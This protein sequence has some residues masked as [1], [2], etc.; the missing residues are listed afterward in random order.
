MKL[1]I[2]K[3]DELNTYYNN[4]SWYWSKLKAS[5]GK[6]TLKS[7]KSL[8]IEFNNNDQLLDLKIDGKYSNDS[9]SSI[10]ID[11]SNDSNDIQFEVTS[12]ELSYIKYPNQIY[13]GGYQHIDGRNIDI[14]KQIECDIDDIFHQDI[15][16]YAVALAAN[17]TTN[18]ANI[19]IRNSQIQNDLNN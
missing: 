9:L 13:S 6:S 4:S 16:R 19:Q 1:Y 7:F 11:T 8:D 10:F 5:F 2:Y 15:V 14:T 3:Q 12:V 17:D 18:A